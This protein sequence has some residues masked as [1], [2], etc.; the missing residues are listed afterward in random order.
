MTAKT[1]LPAL[2][3]TIYGGGFGV[4]DSQLGM[5]IHHDQGDATR[6][7]LENTE[8]MSTIQDYD[9]NPNYASGKVIG[10]E[11]I[12]KYPYHENASNRYSIPE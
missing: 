6:Y 7:T 12:A 10:V 3:R 4:N 1:Q 11:E 9:D 2:Y 8:G 5:S